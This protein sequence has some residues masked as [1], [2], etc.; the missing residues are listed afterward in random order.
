M[1]TKIAL[2]F[3]IIL[4]M[5]FKCKNQDDPGK[6]VIKTNE[7]CDEYTSLPDGSPEQEVWVRA[8]S[9]NLCDG[10]LFAC[11]LTNHRI[12]AVTFNTMKKDYW[13]SKPEIITKKT[14]REVSSFINTLD[15]GNEYL[16]FDIN[17][18]TINRFR[19]INGYTQN[20]TCYSVPLFKAIDLIN[21]GLKDSDIFEFVLGKNSQNN[22]IV[23]FSI[24]GQIGQQYYDLTTDPMFTFSSFLNK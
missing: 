22:T 21:N 3:F 1:K 17:G 4:L 10:Q 20:E 14:W 2:L 23:L 15:C 7:L 13:Q 18:D 11:V 19:K 16:G 5:N 8:H 6:S 9:E 12:D 24:N